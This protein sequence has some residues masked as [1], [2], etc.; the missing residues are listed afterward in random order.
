MIAGDRG[1]LDAGEPG[2]AFEQRPGESVLFDEV[3]PLPEIVS[4]ATLKAG[5]FRNDRRAYRRSLAITAY[6][7]IA[8][9]AHA[10]CRRT[11]DS[12]SFNAAT[13]PVVAR[14]S[15]IA[16]SAQAAC[17]RTLLSASRSASISA[18]TA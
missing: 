16:P 1:R 7:P 13:R 12:V 15:P 8:P 10:A 11:P 5:V 14:E 6:L 3:R 4:P 17:S 18:G 2:R 9:R